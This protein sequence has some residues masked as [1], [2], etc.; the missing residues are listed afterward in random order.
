MR[1][2]SLG[3]LGTPPGGAMTFG[4][5]VGNTVPVIL[6]GMTEVEGDG[7]TT[8]VGG[9][10]KAVALSVP[11]GL[12]LCG[13]VVLGATTA[14]VSVPVA[15]EAEL[16]T[17]SPEAITAVE[18]EPVDVTPDSEVVPSGE[19]RPIVE[20]VAVAVT[21][22]LPKVVP[23]DAE[24][25]ADPV[26][27]TKAELCATLSDAEAALAEFVT[28]AEPDVT[29]EVGTPVS[30]AD[31]EL[32]A[33]VAVVVSR[34]IEADGNPV[35]LVTGEVGITSELDVTGRTGIISEVDVIGMTGITPELVMTGAIEDKPDASESGMFVVGIADETPSVAETEGSS[36]ETSGTVD[37]TDVGRSEGSAEDTA[38]TNGTELCPVPKAE[39][40]T[41]LERM[42]GSIITGIVVSVEDTAAVETE[43]PPLVEVPSIVSNPTVIPDEVSNGVPGSVVGRELIAVVM[44]GMTTEGRIPVD[45]PTMVLAA[46]LGLV[47]PPLVTEV[48]PMGTTGTTP[49]LEAAVTDAES[50][51]PEE[52]VAAVTSGRVVTVPTMVWPALL[53]PITLVERTSDPRLFVAVTITDDTAEGDDVSLGGG[54]VVTGGTLLSV[55][56]RVGRDEAII[57]GEDSL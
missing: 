40:V 46:T 16:E 2:E 57:T 44:A 48:S 3:A 21:D 52:L 34:A 27:K 50:G 49:V 26:S 31:P 4:R 37:K 45:D 7:A 13:A 9:T 15:A 42:L 23:E 12:M 22:S 6:D 43:T 1:I 56:S 11:V 28:G 18:A 19:A 55:V 32:A 54:A 20:T 36:E 33:P 14:R 5:V 29:V 35:T 25:L 24:R 47:T 41:P 39:E 8:I 51:P 53:N 38:V 10:V 30:K 17:E